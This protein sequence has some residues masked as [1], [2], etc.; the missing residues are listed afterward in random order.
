LAAA[1][2]AYS[3]IFKTQFGTSETLL[4]LMLNYVALYLVQYLM[5]GPWRDPTAGGFSK[6]AQF[7]E[8]AWIDQIA[9]V[10]SVDSGCGACYFLFIYFK[11]TKHGFEISVWATR[12]NTARY[13]GMN[14]NKIVIRTMFIS[15]DMRPGRHA[16]VAVMQQLTHLARHCQAGRL[17]FNY[18]GMACKAQSFGSC[19]FVYVWSA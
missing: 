16:S 18:C 14:V 1:C 8:I 7:P 12:Q 6:I 2:S 5:D 9:K 10:M 19:R 11:Y 15:A 3:G 17:Y 13:A 4:T